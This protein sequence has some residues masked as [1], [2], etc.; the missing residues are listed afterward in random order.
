MKIEI[1]VKL[2]FFIIIIYYFFKNIISNLLKWNMSS[3]YY[4]DNLI[5]LHIKGSTR[6]LSAK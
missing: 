2:Y 5:E 1:S 3:R 4:T 6:D